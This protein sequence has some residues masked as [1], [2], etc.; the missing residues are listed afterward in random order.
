VP[1]KRPSREPQKASKTKKTMWETLKK[2]LTG[3][4]LG[5]TTPQLERAG[6]HAACSLISAAPK[7]RE[8]PAHV[9]IEIY[10]FEARRRSK[11]KF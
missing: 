4:G 10:D 6:K 11:N 5:P 7:E 2:A 8:E 3:A 1:R 9:R